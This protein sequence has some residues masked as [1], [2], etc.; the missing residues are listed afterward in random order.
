[1]RLRGLPLRPFELFGL[2]VT[3][4]PLL[5]GGL[6]V[7]GFRFDA[8]DSNLANAAKQPQPLSL[9]WCTDCSG[10]PP[11]TWRHLVGVRTLVLD[12]LRYRRHPTHFSLEESLHVAEKVG[13]DA[14]WF[15]HM[16]HDVQHAELEP[17]LPQGVRLAWDGLTV[18]G[19]GDD[20]ATDDGKTKKGGREDGLLRST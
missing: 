4:L 10:V 13:A 14:T 5:H 8:L 17:K 19:R 18:G 3:P 6:P 15:V 7:L 12:M 20:A 9:A 1:M 11:E 2:Q 16:S